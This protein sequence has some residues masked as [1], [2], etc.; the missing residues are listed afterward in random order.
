MKFQPQT[1]CAVTGMALMV[2][3]TGCGKSPSKAQLETGGEACRQFI[4]KEM[5]SDV[6]FAKNIETQ[7]NDAW[8]KDGKVVFEVAY[9]EEYSRKSYSIRLCVVDEEKGTLMSPSPLNSSKWEK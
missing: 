1:I 8:M 5:K 4:A 3:L 6:A 7:I 9:R 2:A